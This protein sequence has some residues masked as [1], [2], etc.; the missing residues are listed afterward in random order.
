MDSSCGTLDTSG[1]GAVGQQLSPTQIHAGLDDLV[2]Y[3]YA[4]STQN[5]SRIRFSQTTAAS[6]CDRESE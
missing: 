3:F 2:G 6:R 5:R 4:T 1:L